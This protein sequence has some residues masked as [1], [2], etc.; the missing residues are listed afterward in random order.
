MWRRLCCV[1]EIPC[2]TSGA[3]FGVVGL[4]ACKQVGDKGRVH[5][6]EPQPL[7]AQCLRTSVV[8]NGYR[9]A[10][11]HECALSNRRGSAEM[12]ITN[13]GNLGMTTLACEGKRLDGEK[14]HVRLEQAGE[15]I[16]ALECRQVSLVKIDVEGH[17]GVILDS[18]QGWLQE[19]KP[20][21]VLF[22][23]KVGKDGFWAEHTVTLLSSM[24]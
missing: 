20:G 13:A 1:L 10:V 11:V 5:M 18:M 3:N 7:V 22:E 17:E 24:G 16:R 21:V 8:I 9:Q 4:F 15:F 12:T 19:V 23:C 2:W 14:I 6:F